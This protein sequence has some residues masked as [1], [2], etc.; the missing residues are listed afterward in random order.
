MNIILREVDTIFRQSLK[1]R[2]Y[3]GYRSCPLQW[4][5]RG[6]VDGHDGEEVT[7]RVRT[8]DMEDMYGVPRMK[9][10]TGEYWNCYLDALVL[11]RGDEEK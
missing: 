5:M 8:R 9:F 3:L 6:V 10:R 2:L 11:Q 7:R 4:G 1:V